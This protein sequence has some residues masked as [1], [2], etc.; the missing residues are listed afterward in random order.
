[1]QR[2]G[3][4]LD[5][6]R[7]VLAHRVTAIRGL[8]ESLQTEM[9]GPLSEEEWTVM[10]RHPVLG[11]HILVQVGGF[12]ELLSHIVVAHHER[13]DG[14]GY[15]HGLAQSAIP[16]GARILTVVDSYDAMTSE[17]P[18][19][20]PLSD[21]QARAELLRCAG[22]QYDPQVVEVF[23]LALD[24][25]ELAQAPVLMEEVQGDMT[26]SQPA[27]ELLDRETLRS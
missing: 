15:P 19:R 4:A 18:Y 6:C 3:T 10:R 11:Q 27:G 7:E 9:P 20:Q 2:N 14:H 1:M 22:S 13:W 21:A 8:S 17:R 26:P 12:F 23:L 5:E 25:D 16:L 24:A